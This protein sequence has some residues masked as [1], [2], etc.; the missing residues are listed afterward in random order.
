MIRGT[1]KFL[2]LS[3]AMLGVSAFGAMAAD[4]VA[5]AGLISSGYADVFAAYSFLGGD[6][7]SEDDEFLSGGGAFRWSMPV[8]DAMSLQL[9]AA[10]EIT[11]NSGSN[12]ADYENSIGGALHLSYRDPSSHLFG[13]FGG[14]LNSGVGDNGSVDGYFI[15]GEGQYY[16]DMNTFYVQ[17]GYLDGKT[18]NDDTD[19]DGVLGD[20]WFARGVWRHYF[21]EVTRLS[22]E[23]SYANG[24]VDEEPDTDVIGWGA[25]LETAPADWPMSVYLGYEGSYYDQEPGESDTLDEHMIKIGARF[26]FG[27]GSVFERD[28]LGAGL[29]TP[30]FGRW[31][32]IAGG[33]LE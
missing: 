27:A 31:L 26:D 29:D 25:E 12:E 14:V 3:T 2:A 9:D 15:G 13:I 18:S 17:A 23:G 10:G 22:L 1:I 6:F 33:P 32:G 4:P 19:D 21:S 20:A 16:A 24:Q 30:R 5:E 28:R 8:G 11:E 7:G